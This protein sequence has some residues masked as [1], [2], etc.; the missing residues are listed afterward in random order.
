MKVLS[1]E[2][3]DGI[4]IKTHELPNS[5]PVEAYYLDDY[6]VERDAQGFVKSDGR[7]RG[8]QIQASGRIVTVRCP[9]PPSADFLSIYPHGAPK[10]TVRSAKAIHFQSPAD[11]IV[12]PIY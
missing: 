3:V 9:T 6:L 7:Y 11:S 12:W 10:L 5:D 2:V 8:V 4:L 1:L